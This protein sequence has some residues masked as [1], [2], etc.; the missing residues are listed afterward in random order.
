[1][2]GN[3]TPK[4]AVRFYSQSFVLQFLPFFRFLILSVRLLLSLQLLLTLNLTLH[5][6]QAAAVVETAVQGH[7]TVPCRVAP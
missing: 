3:K 5:G 7:A 4:E 2:S 1:V 6:Q